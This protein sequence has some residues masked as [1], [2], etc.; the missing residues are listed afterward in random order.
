MKIWKLAKSYT[1]TAYLKGENGQQIKTKY[2]TVSAAKESA[3]EWAKMKVMVK[4]ADVIDSKT[5][6]VLAIEIA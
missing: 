5:G 4:M 1:V 3:R 6:E 2:A